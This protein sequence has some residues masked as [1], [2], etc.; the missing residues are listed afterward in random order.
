MEHSHQHHDTPQ[1]QIMGIKPATGSDNQAKTHTDNNKST[2]THEPKIV[3]YLSGL[4][5]GLI[6]VALCL[7]VF[8]V[9]LVCLHQIL[10]SLWNIQSNHRIP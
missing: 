7:S 8:L 1:E 4:R 2:E 5:L 9:A 6:F 10:V 3:N